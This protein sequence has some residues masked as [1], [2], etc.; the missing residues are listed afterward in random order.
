M[1]GKLAITAGLV[2]GIVVGGAAFAAVLVL[3]PPPVLAPPTTP[4]ASDA[5]LPVPSAPA[6]SPSTGAPGSVAPS[7]SS[8]PSVSPA[9]A[10]GSASS[11]P[12]TA[13]SPAA[14]DLFGVGQ[15][16]P[17]LRV[18]RL[19]GGEIDLAALKGKPV[20]VYFMATWCP[21]CRD[22]L[23]LMNGF[24]VRYADVG[25]TAVAVDVREDPASVGALMKAVGAQLPTGLDLDGRAQQAWKALA[26]PV[27]FWV[28]RDGIIR[29]GALG[30]I[31][32]DVMAQG[33]S[34][35]LPGVD[36]TP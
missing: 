12:G 4:A 6:S 25:L 14:G 28:D 8:V 31:G 35:I 9:P 16:A 27:H 23:P 26:L 24:A 33:L 10:S 20:W 21:S 1:G 11:S 18:G 13:S 34:S 19:G 3:T 7:A 29:F 17:S 36:V 22:E 15:P 30:G 2:A 5:P 32:P